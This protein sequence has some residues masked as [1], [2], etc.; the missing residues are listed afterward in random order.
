VRRITEV[1]PG[2][3][4]VTAASGDKFVEDRE[5]K[6]RL[7][8]LGCGIVDMEIAAIARVCERSGVRC[9]SI[10]CISDTFEGDGGDFNANVRN[11]ANKAFAVIRKAIK[12]ATA[13][14]A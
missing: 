10:K 3:R 9:M 6:I 13:G 12:A 4:K 11:S 5:E 1:I 14:K 2:L 7:R 8:G